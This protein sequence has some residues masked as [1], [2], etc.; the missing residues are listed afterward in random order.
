MDKTAGVLF[1]ITS[2]P[3]KYG[4]GCFSKEAYKFVDWLADAGQRY[5]QILPMGPTGFGDSPYQSFSTFAGNPYFID[6]ETLICEGLLKKEECDSRDFGADWHFVDYEKQY[7]ERYGLL[8]LAYERSRCFDTYEYREFLN[9]NSYWLTDYSLYM[10]VKNHFGG[11]VWTDWPEEIRSRTE[12]GISYYRGVLA[13]EIGF[14]QFMQYL[15]FKQWNELRAYANEKGIKIVGD[16]PIYVSLDSADAWSHPELFQLDENCNPVAVAGCP[17]DGFSADG[18][19]WG[20]PLYNWTYHRQTG[21]EWWTRRLAFCFELYDVLRID[22]FRGFDEYY[23]IPYGDKTAVHGHWEKGPGISLFETIERN[24]GKKSVIAEDLGFVTDSV[25]KLVRDSDF[26]GM[27]VLQF[28]FDSRDTGSA[29]DYLP[30]NYISNCIAYTG[31]HD[32]ETLIGWWITQDE[33]TKKTVRDYLCDYYTPD[34]KIHIPLI[35][36]I[37]RSNAKICIVP[38]QDYLGLDNCARMNTPSTV[39]KNWRWRADSSQIDGVLAKA[40]RDITERF[41]RLNK[42]K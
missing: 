31:T 42:T 13:D 36:S 19:L 18:Q 1:A 25:R 14:Q 3:S 11:I 37:M 20:N 15:F 7:N 8:R 33:D 2:L 29:N 12:E 9:K 4:I 24:I 41:G 26:P 39:G 32:N 10:A 22:H 38:L 5:W 40:V 16:I 17:P 27:K 6:L 28:A 21:Y 35:A 30:H 34:D 23:S